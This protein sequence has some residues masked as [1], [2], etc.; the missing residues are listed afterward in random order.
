MIQGRGGPGRRIVGCDALVL[1]VVA[2]RYAHGLEAASG[3]AEVE[4][5]RRWAVK[6]RVLAHGFCA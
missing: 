4:G 2:S 3:Y 5:A 1:S 6:A